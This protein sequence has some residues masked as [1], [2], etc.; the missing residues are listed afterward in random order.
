MDPPLFLSLFLFYLN[1]CNYTQIMM[2]IIVLH[3]Q[4]S[5][6]LVKT[7]NRR[8]SPFGKQPNRGH[9]IKLLS[10]SQ[11]PGRDVDVKEVTT[12]VILR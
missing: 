1:V 9:F 10:R 2:N 3:Q 6:P 11:V 7:P 4:G 12:G 8:P 5:V